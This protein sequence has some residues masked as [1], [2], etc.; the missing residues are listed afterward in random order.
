MVLIPLIFNFSKSQK[1]G[2]QR[3]NFTNLLTTPKKTLNLR[4]RNLSKLKGPTAPYS[5]IKNREVDNYRLISLIIV[6]KVL[7]QIVLLK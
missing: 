1:F 7:N 2:T 6:K 3:I 5:Q 4:T